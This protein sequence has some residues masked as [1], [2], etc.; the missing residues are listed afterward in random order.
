VQEALTN[1]L[2]HAATP[3]VE[4]HLRYLPDSVQLRI[5][6]TG[7]TDPRARAGNGLIGMRERVA[8]YGGWLEA[9][10]QV[11]GRFLVNATLPLNGAIP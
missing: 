3:Q 7:T 4:V 10:A 9:G 2:K 5:S 6:N 11:D 1:V 8:L